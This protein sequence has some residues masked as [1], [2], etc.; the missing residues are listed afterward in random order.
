MVKA[1]ELIKRLLDIIEKH[2]DQEVTIEEDGSSCCISNIEVR[3]YSPT[4]IEINLY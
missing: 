4:W 1:S 3:D 2:G